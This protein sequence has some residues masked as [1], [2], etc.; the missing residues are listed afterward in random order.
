MTMAATPASSF[1]HIMHELNEASGT[2]ATRWAEVLGAPFGSAAFAVRHAA[3]MEAFHYTARA[4]EAEPPGRAREARH[5]QLP[6]WW[7]S[8]VGPEIPWNQ[9]HNMAL[10]EQSLRMLDTTAERLEELQA[11]GH[12]EDPD[13]AK[14]DDLLA[15]AQKW[16]A[17]VLEERTLNRGLQLTLAQHLESLIWTIENAER[18]GVG[19]VIPAADRASGALMRATTSTP[20]LWNR[21]G[22]GLVAFVAAITVLTTGYNQAVDAVEH[23]HTIIQELAPG[24]AG[25]PAS[26]EADTG[27]P[28]D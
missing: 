6:A 27:R 9:N 5:A 1:A 7:K 13:S 17:D 19:L 2:P 11:G 16:L 20:G 15:Q 8:V 21:W 23:T 10:D 14:L 25:E 3:V 28:G 26:N 24:G 12:S 18:F 4:I 22:K